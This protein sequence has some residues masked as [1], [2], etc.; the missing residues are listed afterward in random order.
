MPL[1]DV[2]NL[3]LTLK[4]SQRKIL[5]NV[6]FSLKKSE[7]L[8]I[9]GESGSG[10]S[11]TALSLLGLLDESV[12][13]IHGEILF[14]GKKLKNEKDF[15]EIRG[16]NITYIFQ[17]PISSLNPLHKIGKQVQEAYDLHHKNDCQQSS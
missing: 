7:I 12:F 10:K 8:G 4:S 14:D 6:S 3:S 1:L 17:E 15:S 9:V 11:V 5:K 16:K 2:K 13:D